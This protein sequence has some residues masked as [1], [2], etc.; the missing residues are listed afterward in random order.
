MRCAPVVLAL[1]LALPA[2][3][4]AQPRIALEP[5][6]LELGVMGQNETRD[7]V[8]VIR[9]DGDQ[10]LIIR[11]IESTCGCTVPELKVTE[12]APGASTEMEIHFNS[13]TFQGPQTKYVHVFS[14]D[15]GRGAVDLLITADITV[16]LRM[17][18][19]KSQLGF[20]TLQVGETQTLSYT[21]EAE[22]LDELEIT[23]SDWPQ[24]WLDIEVRPGRTPNTVLVDFVVKLDAEPGRHRDPVKLRTNVPEMPLISLTTDVKLISD[25]VVTPDKINLRMLRPEQ[26]VKT[27]VRLSPYRPGTEFEVLSAEVDIPGLRVRVENGAQETTIWL[28]GQSLSADHERVADNGAVRGLITVRTNL[29]GTPEITIPVMYMVRR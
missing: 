10:T 3:A 9:N 21:F 15:P 12:L 22:D 29:A 4:V 11:D 28:D 14:N 5:G 23:P 17:T 2:V 26:A 18:P 8:V 6:H 19:A 24:G 1:S 20:R 13:K 16:P 7:S 27:R 25:L